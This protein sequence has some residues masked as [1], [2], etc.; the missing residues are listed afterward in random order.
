[1][2]CVCPID[3]LRHAKATAGVELLLQVT[4]VRGARQMHALHSS[5]A[6][7]ITQSALLTL[8]DRSSEEEERWQHSHSHRLRDGILTSEGVPT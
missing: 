1:M 6:R 5:R 3:V 4:A 7:Y 2:Q 8:P